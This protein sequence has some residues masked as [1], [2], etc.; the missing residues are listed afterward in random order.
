MRFGEFFI[1]C[2]YF[3]LYVVWKILTKESKSPTNQQYAAALGTGTAA[4]DDFTN[5]TQ[6]QVRLG[7][8]FGVRI[9]CVIG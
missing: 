7:Y 3:Y 8:A 9:V 1:S 6:T 5:A 4:S 2:V